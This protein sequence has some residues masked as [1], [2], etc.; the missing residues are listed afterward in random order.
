[1]EGDAEPGVGMFAPC[2]G[3]MA[4]EEGVGLEQGQAI[5]GL[6]QGQAVPR[7]SREQ[8]PIVPLHLKEVTSVPSLPLPHP[9]AVL[10]SDWGHRFHRERISPAGSRG[11]CEACSPW[12]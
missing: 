11:G 9:L 8:G 6:E 3:V 2:H 4:V 12:L 10:P 5:Y 7:C 1:M